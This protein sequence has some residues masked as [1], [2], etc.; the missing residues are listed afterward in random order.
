M[1][2]RYNRLEPLTQ[3]DP[4]QPRRIEEK[5]DRK[6]R[7]AKERRLAYLEIKARR[8]KLPPIYVPKAGG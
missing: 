7:K 4:Y 1:T 2:Y 3:Y 6:D 5:N 8:E